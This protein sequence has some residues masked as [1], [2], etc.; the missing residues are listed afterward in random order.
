MSDGSCKVEVVDAHADSVRCIAADPTPT[1]SSEV[2]LFATGSYDGFIK[3]WEFKLSDNSFHTR[4]KFLHGQSVESI[5]YFPNGT[6]LVSAGG[7]EVKVWDTCG[8]GRLLHSIQAHVQTVT[9]KSV[10][11]SSTMF[12]FG[13]SDCLLGSIDLQ[14]DTRTF[15]SIPTPLGVAV[16]DDSSYIVTGSLDQ[17]VKFHCPSEFRVLHSLHLDETVSTLNTYR[18]A[19]GA[20]MLLIGLR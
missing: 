14:E 13:V 6:L 3:V 8:A 17:T 12:M 18:A 20:E 19:D 4:H 10:F 16:A 7:T 9:C 15:V 11:T 5:A 2:H 1:Q